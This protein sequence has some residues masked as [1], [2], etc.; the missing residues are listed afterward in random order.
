MT[1]SREDESVDAMNNSRLWLTRMAKGRKLRVLD[2]M[3]SLGLR[4][5]STTSALDLKV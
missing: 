5:T 3:K 2:D 1:L 4:L